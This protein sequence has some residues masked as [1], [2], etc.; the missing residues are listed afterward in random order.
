MTAPASLTTQGSPSG[1]TEMAVAPPL[2]TSH[3]WVPV[4]GTQ[5]MTWCP[6]AMVALA[7]PHTDPSVPAAMSDR[8]STLT[9]L[10]SWPRSHVS[11]PIALR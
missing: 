10:G 8:P 2:T 3:E 6:P 5:R 7:S 4:P 1:P 9:T 11:L